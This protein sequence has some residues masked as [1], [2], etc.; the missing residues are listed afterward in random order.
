MIE[1]V[2][3][4]KKRV[5]SKKS[6]AAKTASK[7]IA[8]HSAASPDWGTPG[9][10]RRFAQA[11]LSPSAFSACIDLDY[12]S[13]AY[14]QDH[15]PDG[16]RPAAY[17]DGTKGRDVL[18]EAD[19]R[20]A[21]TGHGCG[22]G[23]E[24]PPGLDG[25]QMIQRCWEIFE[26]DHRTGWLHSGFWLGFSIEHFA[27]LQGVSERNPLSGGDLIATIVPCRRIRYELHPKAL[28]ELLLKKQKKR[29]KTSKQWQIEQRQ[30]K[31]LRARTDDAPVPGLAPT[32]ASYIT[33]LM[34]EK[35]TV[36][37]Q[38]IEA[39]KQFLAAEAKD[40]RSPFQRYEVIGSL[41]MR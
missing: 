9:V 20:A 26:T 41:E 8:M 30:L 34:S 6:L 27:S 12:S 33:L 38:Q 7:A 13:S 24:N 10:V 11:F 2:E 32:H 23:F 31:R 35:K 22:A 1:V 16:H 37:R 18:V 5:S 28:I 15:W 17:L 4:K 14:W 21:V 3:M 40:E 29:D 25:G 39:A 36:R 19:R